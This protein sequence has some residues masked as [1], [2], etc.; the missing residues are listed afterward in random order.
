MIWEVVNC[1]RASKM[2]QKSDG[3]VCWPDLYIQITRLQNLFKTNFSLNSCPVSLK[4]FDWYQGQKIIKQKESL[5]VHNKPLSV[6]PGLAGVLNGEGA[7]EVDHDHIS[8]FAPAAGQENLVQESVQ[9]LPLF[10]RHQKMTKLS[11]K[12]LNF[13]FYL[14]SSKM[15]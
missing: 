1:L 2:A 4:T 12:S 3:H 11:W 10:Y 6:V 5:I 8:I 14:F 7:Q 9:H 15:I 13:I